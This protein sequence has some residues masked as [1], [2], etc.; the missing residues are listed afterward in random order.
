MPG[1]ANNTH[2][3]GL[4]IICVKENSQMSAEQNKAIVRRWYQDVFEKGNL[5]LANEIFTA[6]YTS[7]DPSAPPGGWPRGPEG[8]KA[9]VA[10]YRGAFPDIQFTIDDQVA[11]GDKVVTRWT[12][13][14]TNTG[15]LM[16]MP[17]TGK[18][19]VVTG[20]NIDRIANGK[21]AETWGNFDALGMLQQIGAIPA[22]Q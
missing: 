2:E 4:R 3:R 22:P 9:L 19:A 15:E 6:D 16:G 5:A 20:I 10:T 8:A 12:G 21:I 11:E 17:P 13:R 7:H 18:K 1:D 14:G